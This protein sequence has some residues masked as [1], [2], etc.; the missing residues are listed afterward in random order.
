MTRITNMCG[1]QP[2]SS[3]WLFKSPL[4]G[5][6]GTMWR[7][8]TGCLLL[9]TV[10]VNYCFEKHRCKLEALGNHKSPLR[11][12]VQQISYN[13]PLKNYLVGWRYTSAP[14]RWMG[15]RL[16]KIS[17]KF[18]DSFLTYQQ[19]LYYSPHPAWSRILFKSPTSERDPDLHQYL[20][21]CFLSH[22]PLLQKFC[23]LSTTFLVILLTDKPTRQKHNLLGGDWRSMNLWWTSTLIRCY[24]FRWR[25]WISVLIN[26]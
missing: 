20:I 5:S 16:S 23:Q 21:F 15:C 22:L 7:P 1:D 13:C 3:A 24:M 4:A 2:E 19:T 6:G 25:F 8:S 12:F 9:L 14:K 17:S 10:F 26:C 11:H 18:V